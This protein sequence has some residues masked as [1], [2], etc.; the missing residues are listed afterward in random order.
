MTKLVLNKIILIL[1]FVL[2]FTPVISQNNDFPYLKAKSEFEYKNYDNALKNINNAIGINNKNYL[3]Y[4]LRAK[5]YLKQNK[6]NLAI[7]D[8]EKSNYLKNNSANFLLSRAY[9]LNNNYIKADKY[10]RLYLKQKN[11]LPKPK[12]FLCKDFDKFNKTKYWNDIWKKNWYS[13]IDMF[14]QTINYLINN[15]KYTEA[16]E[17]LDVRI[18]KKKRYKD[19]YYKSL[20]LYKLND[21][22]NSLKNI[23]IAVKLSRKEELYILRG[24]IYLKLNKPKKAVNDF[25][26]AEKLN[27]YNIHIKF[28]LS[29]SYYNA[30]KYDY[31]ASTINDYLQFYYKNDTALGLAG[32]IY[33]KKEEFFKSIKYY[34]KAI[35]LNV[36]NGN[37]YEG[38]G[39]DFYITQAYKFAIKDFSVALDINPKNGE[40]YYL[41]GI[42]FFNL[43][44]LKNACADWKNAM[45]NKYT[46]A[47]NY[48]RLNCQ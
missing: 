36:K 38:R 19:L 34:N 18:N 41:R 5:I 30:K 40:I 10:L 44:D 8:L 2:S 11:K 21:Y 23:K 45:D 22:S 29:K 42:S 32:D 12:V 16:L 28:L 17:Q 6:I 37:Y 1:F 15:Q 48:I 39:R 43:D 25:L 4:L 20:I 13:S 31:A 35:K 26:F 46:D 7:K 9:S 24:K 33:Y 3:N 47:Y 14:Y 27:K